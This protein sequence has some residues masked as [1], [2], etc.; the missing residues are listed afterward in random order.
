MAA[1]ITIDRE[2]LVEFKKFVGKN[3]K[4][5]TQSVKKGTFT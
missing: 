4:E 2:K 1:G 3:L 5:F